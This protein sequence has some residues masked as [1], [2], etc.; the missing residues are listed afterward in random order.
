[1]HVPWGLLQHCPL[2]I[3]CIQYF[4]AHNCLT[5]RLEDMPSHRMLVASAVHCQVLWTSSVSVEGSPTRAFLSSISSL[6][7][8][9]AQVSLIGTHPGNCLSSTR[10]ELVQPWHNRQS[11]PYLRFSSYYTSELSTH[12]T[13]SWCCGASAHI[14]T[15]AGSLARGSAGFVSLQHA[16]AKDLSARLGVNASRVQLRSATPAALPSTRHLL[17]V[18]LSD[19]VQL[20]CPRSIYGSAIHSWTGWSPAATIVYSSF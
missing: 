11:L 13:G 16:L 10:A 12:C 3:L 17:A 1:M 20:C 18:S 19:A 5:S 9:E 8:M 2:P 15:C 4:D 14:C 7:P 6:P